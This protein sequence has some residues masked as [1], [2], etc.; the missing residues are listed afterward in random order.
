[1]AIAL[2]SAGVILAM[3]ALCARN[4]W[5]AVF[6]IAAV[7]FF[8]AAYGVGLLDVSIFVLALSCAA[9]VMIVF[10]WVSSWVADVQDEQPPSAVRTSRTGALR[11]ASLTCCVLIGLLVLVWV[12]P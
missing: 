6:L 10:A 11:S 7:I 12:R 8:W 1:M 4:I 5:A 2:T 3:I 9:G